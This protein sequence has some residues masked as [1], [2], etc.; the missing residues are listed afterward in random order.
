MA[1]S[2]RWLPAVLGAVALCAL[3]VAGGLVY[4]AWGA[5]ARDTLVTQMLINLILVMGLQVFIGNTG[6]LSFGHMAFGAIAGYT[7]ALLSIPALLKSRL[8]PRAPWG[9]TDVEVHPFWATLAGVGVALVVGVLVGL[10]LTRS[11]ARSGATAATMITLAFLFVVHA[12][13]LNWNDLTAG[14]GGLSFGPGGRMEGRGWIYLALVLSVVAAR[15]FAETRTG[16]FAKAGREDELA[17]RASG[18]GLGGPQLVALLLSVVIVAVGASLRVQVLGSITPLFFYFDFTLLTLAMLIVG[19]RSSVT[20][21]VVGVAV[22]TVGNELTRYLSQDVELTGTGWLFKPGLSDLFLGGA[23]VGFMLLRPRGLIGDWELD[24]WFRRSPRDAPPPPPP[25]PPPSPLP[26]P[27]ATAPEVATPTAAASVVATPLADRGAAPRLVVEGLSVRF[28][29]F[30]ALDQVSIEAASD[31]VVGLIGPNG[32]GKTT[33]LN[34]LTGVIQ[35]DAGHVH[36]DGHD[37]TGAPAEVVARAGL[38]RTFQNL[39]LFTELSVRENVAVAA[40]A[41]AR[42]RAGRPAA[43]VARLLT[44]AGLWPERDRLAGELD[45]GSQRRLELARAAALSP[46][47]LLLDEPTSGM[48]ETE[49][50]A[51]IDHVRTTAANAA[52]GVLVI[53]HDLHFITS[54]CDRIYVLDHGQ[55]L[56]HG[57]TEEIQRDPKVIEAYLG[58]AAAP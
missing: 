43:D 9:I 28:G 46:T 25:P 42:H 34:A 23:M 56:A 16:R 58:S 37:L 29:G 47:F 51:M 40:I 38:A 22:I 36:V 44:D 57:T 14:G 2:T 7:V 3:V 32:A 53:D 17:A 19:G 35:P 15:L 1:R 5:T 4:A 18:I 21:A 41:A 49:S 30:R 20:G 33:L 31:E 6:I 54:V 12:V 39:R 48:G 52:A 24:R 13:A 45:Y 50:A 26:S 11:G 8:I 27:T 10:A 55:L